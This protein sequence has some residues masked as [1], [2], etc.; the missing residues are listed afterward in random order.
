MADEPPSQNASTRWIETSQGILSYSQLAPLL[1]ERVLRVQEQV[2][3]GFY[4][5]DDFDE[6]LAC[7]L[8]RDFC[9]DLVPDWSGKWRTMEVRVGTHEPPLPHLVPMQMREYVLDLQGRLASAT[10][11]EHLPEMLAFAEGRLLSIHP[12]ADFNGRLAR[13]W[14]WELMRRLQ[15]PPV[16]LVSLNPSLTRKYL[17]SLRC[18]D[19]ND[20]NS[21]AELWKERLLRAGDS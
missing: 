17:E 15:L 13:L 7:K 11:P 8:H 9:G 18:A 6:I 3:A 12:F 1:A 2:E 19:R 10:S 4:H 14:L 20:Y 21:L 5:A 16:E